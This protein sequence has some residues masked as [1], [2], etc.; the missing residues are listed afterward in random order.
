MNTKK[1]VKTWFLSSVLLLWGLAPSFV[2]AQLVQGE[3]VDAELVAE[4]QEA[5][6]GES[7]WLALRLDHL[8]KWHTYWINPGDAGKATEINWQLPEGVSAGEIVWP[9][10]EKFVWPIGLVDFGYEDEVFLLTELSVPE[11]YSS[12]VLPVNAE[13][14]WLECDDV[15]CIP[16]GASLSLSIPVNLDGGPVNPS[17]WQAAFDATRAQIPDNSVSIDGTYS[18]DESNLNLLL[19]ATDPI[20]EEALGISFIPD[21]HRVVDYTAEQ[22]ITSQLSSM[23][24]SQ[25]AHSRS[26]REPPESL[27][28]LL[29]VEE[30][31][32]SIAAYEVEAVPDE[33]SMSALAGAV[34]QNE[35]SMA[36]GNEMS[37]FTVFAFA[38]LGGVILNL[39]PCVFP[40]LSLK[41]MSLAAH[42]DSHPR[43]QKLHGIAYAAGV[44]L[45]FLVLA[46]VLLGL[47]AGGAAIGWGFH[48]QSPWFVGA[49]VYLFFIMGL[50]MSGV[51]EIGTGIMGVG[52]ELSDEESYQGS[53]FTGV[54]ASVVASPCTAPFMG[55]AL[56]FAF[57]QPMIIALTV[58]FSLGLGMALPFL[59]FSFVPALARMLPKPGQWML[60]FRQFLAFPLYGTAAWLLWVLGR[61]TS[62]DAMAL[63]V[64]SCVFLGFAAWMYQRERSVKPIWKFAEIALMLLCVLLAFSVLRSPLLTPQQASTVAAEG[65]ENYEVFTNARLAELRSQGEPVFVNMTASW[66]IT[67]LVNE[68]VAL[69][70]ESV[71]AMMIDKDI[72]YLKGDWTNN[73]PEITAVLK[74]YETSGVP[75]YLAFPADPNKPAK[76]LPQILT[77]GLIL[78]TLASL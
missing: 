40:V 14:S 20:F 55:A 35:S 66:C 44:I 72:T 23:Q 60:T 15:T 38:L 65:G 7:L 19:Q 21:R 70:S 49:L 33:V 12:S 28:G 77:E 39:M 9:V 61:Q 37:L 51:I 57:T 24:L 3:H 48:L 41:A 34:P 63:I 1:I 29:L 62:T 31:D 42:A 73:D 16:S 10:P 43:E 30:G 64:L 67:C 52:S 11:N 36:A 53:F 69:S 4:L 8:E 68:R 71:K 17:S 22:Q 58:F 75:L 2:F 59:M 54:L 25:A 46:A 76:I 5:T 50:S 47:Q 56:G 27:G 26:L 32:G 13:V 78:E 74:E 18:F 6:P 45:S